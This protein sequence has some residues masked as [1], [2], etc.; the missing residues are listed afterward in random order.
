MNFFFK[1]LPRD[2]SSFL[3]QLKKNCFDKNANQVTP[4]FPPSNYIFQKSSLSNMPIEFTILLNRQNF[5]RYKKNDMFK[6]S[7]R[8][9]TT[10][11][12]NYR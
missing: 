2:K 7:I 12:Y 9:V 4:I 5:N 1:S 11:S 10:K 8:I 3:E 6:D